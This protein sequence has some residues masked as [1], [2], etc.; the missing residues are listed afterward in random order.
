MVKTV[1][2]WLSPLPL[3][4]LAFGI[5]K[6]AFNYLS[7]ILDDGSIEAQFIACTCLWWHAGGKFQSP[8]SPAHLHKQPQ[9]GLLDTWLGNQ[10]THYTM[11]THP[12][13]LPMPKMEHLLIWDNV[14]KVINLRVLC[15]HNNNENTSNKNS[16]S[17]HFLS[18]HWLA[19]TPLGTWHASSHLVPTGTL[20]DF[21]STLSSSYKQGNWGPEKLHNLAVDTYIPRSI[22]L[23]SPLLF[24]TVLPWSTLSALP[25]SYSVTSPRHTPHPQPGQ[26]WDGV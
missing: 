9:K 6:A 20:R 13:S 25:P 5:L 16:N 10:H 4:C 18:M 1:C 12:H 22:Q 24:T 23:Q 21:G 17:E 3:G 11:L 7:D 19:S 14:T 2:L 15:F 26:S 8:T